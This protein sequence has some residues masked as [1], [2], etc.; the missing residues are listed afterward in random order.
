MTTPAVSVVPIAAQVK[1]VERYL[2]YLLGRAPDRRQGP[3]ARFVDRELDTWRA[4]LETLKRVE[5]S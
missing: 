4:V 2:G 3:S 5:G 1:A